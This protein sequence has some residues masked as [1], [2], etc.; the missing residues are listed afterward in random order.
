M[1]RYKPK[2]ISQISPRDSRLLLVGKVASSSPNSFVLEDE[3]GRIE[4]AFNGNV[5]Q[6]ENVRVFCSFLGNSL[7]ADFLQKLSQ[8]E[9][10]IFK[11]VERL[12]SK[13][14]EYV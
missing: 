7:Q 1:E 4:V 3:T 8:E 14:K 13:V 11:R 2:K 5:Q 9:M 10:N 12:Y 6:G